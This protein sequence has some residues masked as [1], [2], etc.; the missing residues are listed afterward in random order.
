MNTFNAFTQQY[1]ES[2]LVAESKPPAG[3]TCPIASSFKLGVLQNLKDSGGNQVF[4]PIPANEIDDV[5]TGFVIARNGVLPSKKLWLYKISVDTNGNPVGTARAVSVPSYAVPPGAAQGGGSTQLLATADARNTQAVV[6]RNPARGNALSLWTQHTV[7]AGS[8]SGVRFYEIDPL[9]REV[10]PQS[11]TLTKTGNF[12]FNAAISPDRSVDGTTKQFGDSFA[13]G[14]SESSAVNNINPRIDVVSSVSGGPLSNR[15]TIKSS[16][17]PYIDFSCANPG[18]T[19]RWGDYAGATPEPK[20]SGSTT[21]NIWL[22][23]QFGNGGTSTAQ[24]NWRVE[25]F[26]IQP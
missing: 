21:S 17:G 9:T 10:L 2:D 25:I 16:A 23:N 6:A 20:P 11:G 4:T 26:K 24:A 3:A 13:I 8:T 18:D 7:A 5:S 19:C 15:V 22:D 1:I 12:F 14:F